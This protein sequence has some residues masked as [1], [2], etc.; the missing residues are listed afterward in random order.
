M[1]AVMNHMVG[2]SEACAAAN[3]RILVEAASLAGAAH[4]S[5]P[6]GI[7]VLNRVGSLHDVLAN[8][9]HDMT[10]ALGTAA[11]R[12]GMLVAEV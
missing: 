11:R 12:L 10:E 1:A 7:L 6:L 3:E 2:S 8:A 9:T 4:S 5:P